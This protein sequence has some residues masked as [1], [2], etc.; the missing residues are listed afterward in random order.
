[1]DRD[2]GAGDVEQDARATLLLRAFPKWFCV[3]AI[4][5]WEI[6]AFFPIPGLLPVLEKLSATERCNSDASGR[7]AD[8]FYQSHREDMARSGQ[9]YSG[10]SLDERSDPQARDYNDQKS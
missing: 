7:Q 1:M 8:Y 4:S 10:G 3:L 6:L 5:I 2:R 9:D